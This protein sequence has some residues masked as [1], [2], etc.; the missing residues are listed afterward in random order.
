MHAEGRRFK[1][2]Y[3]HQPCGFAV[4][5]S[6]NR[7]TIRGEVQGSRKPIGER[8]ATVPE[9]VGLVRKCYLARGNS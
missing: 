4:G 9:V 8:V 6:C 7:P 3:L 5:E 1:S 2:D